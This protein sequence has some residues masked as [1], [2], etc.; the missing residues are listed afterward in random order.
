MENVLK[1]SLDT[2]RLSSRPMLINMQNIDEMPDVSM[3]PSFYQHMMISVLM[4]FK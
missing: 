2:A 3:K 4:K 1:M